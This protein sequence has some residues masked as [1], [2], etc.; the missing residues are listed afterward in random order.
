LPNRTSTSSLWI[1][2]PIFDTIFFSFGWLIVLI[3]LVYYQ[4][5]IF[6]AILVGGTIE[7]IRNNPSYLWPSLIL[8]AVLITNYIHRHLTFALVYGEPEEF[9]RR[10]TLYILVP[11]LFAAVTVISIY[12]GKFAVLLVLSLIWN[13]YHTV[14]QKY[15]ITRIYS[16]KAKYG[17]GWLE[18]GVIFSWLFFLIFSVGTKNQPIIM[19]YKAGR[20]I[21]D[22]IGGYAHYFETLSYVALAGALVFTLIYIHN[23][24]KHR[25]QLSVPKNVFLLSTLLLFG[26]FFYNFLIGYVVL[27]FSHAFEYIA[28]VNV[29][30][31]S[32]YKKKDS[33]S[34]LAVASK[35]QWLYSGL[36]SL[37]IVAFC[38]LGINLDE[39][40][41]LMYIVGS[42][43]LHFL[44]DGLIWKVRRPEVGKPL[45]IKYAEA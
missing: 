26:V 32:K 36:F 14:T 33:D 27:G 17:F 19:K 22:F 11:I 45:E 39:N 23:E 28:F 9:N 40:I 8:L 44:Y 10:K 18:K 42:S 6:R 25:A 41:F 12:M 34:P 1:K 30:V 38:L 15:G 31:G 37:F 16:R 3:P 5:E 21:L 29:F 43:F 4:N 35:R 24:F 20:Q 7:G 2:N 13:I